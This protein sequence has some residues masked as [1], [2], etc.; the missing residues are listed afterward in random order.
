MAV[1]LE[2]A[3]LRRESAWVERGGE[4]EGQGEGDEWRCREGARELVGG[5]MRGE[6]GREAE[7][8]E[9]EARRKGGG[10]EGHGGRRK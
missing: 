7:R 5:S 8:G 10:R 2:R 9:M 6:G 1:D 4:K 3:R